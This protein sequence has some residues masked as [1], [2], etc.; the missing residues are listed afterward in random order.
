[1]SKCF[2][3]IFGDRT[4]TALFCLFL[5]PA[6]FH[7]LIFPINTISYSRNKT[8]PTFVVFSKEV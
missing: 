8:K 4:E 2:C 1:M 7:V 6:G 5:F 3:C